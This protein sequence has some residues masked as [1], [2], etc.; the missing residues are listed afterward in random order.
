VTELHGLA[1]AAPKVDVWADA[2]SRAGGFEALLALLDTD[3]VLRGDSVAVLLA[4]LACLSQ[5]DLVLLEK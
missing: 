4:D 3:V 2:A 1:G 5:L